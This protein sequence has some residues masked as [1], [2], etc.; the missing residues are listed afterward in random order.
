MS[1]FWMARTFWL[2]AALVVLV[3][4]P[5]VASASE[6]VSEG[7]VLEVSNP[8]VRTPMPGRAMTAGFAELHNPGPA[9]VVIVGGHCTCSKVVELHVMAE[10][11]GVMRMR[12]VDQFAVPAAGTLELRPG[13]PHLMLIG[14]EGQPLEPGGEVVIELELAGGASQVVTFAVESWKS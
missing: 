14:L 1:R 11:D 7:A 13:G 6:G 5:L 4:S 10:E 12:K 2:A 9:E 8:R 3:T